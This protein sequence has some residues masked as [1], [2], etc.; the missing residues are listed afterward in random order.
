MTS[1]FSSG[2]RGALDRRKVFVTGEVRNTLVFTEG[3]PKLVIKSPLVT[4]TIA[5]AGLYKTRV[6]VE[7][8]RFR[9]LLALGFA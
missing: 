6:F 8:T 4:Q 3:E 2:D 9:P 7:P 5:Q 1:A